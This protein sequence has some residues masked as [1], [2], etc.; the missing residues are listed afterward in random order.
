MLVFKIINIFDMHA[1][2]GLGL[3]RHLKYI[4]VRN[5]KVFMFP[6]YSLNFC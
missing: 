1:N 4:L 2:T 6:T 3:I 5:A